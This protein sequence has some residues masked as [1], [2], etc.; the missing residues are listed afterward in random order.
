MPIKSYLAYPAQG[1][2][3]ELERALNKMPGCDVINAQNRDLL[4]LVT[5]TADKKSEEALETRL[6]ALPELQWLA[7]VA[8]YQDLAK[9]SNS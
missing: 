5:E 3:T 1:K 7:L 6:E 2:R 8:G 9:G 4:I